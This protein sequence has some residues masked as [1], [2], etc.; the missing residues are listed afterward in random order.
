MKRVWL[1]GL[2][3][4]VLLGSAVGLEPA[5]DAQVL[6]VRGADG[7]EEYGKAFAEQVALWETAAGQAGL[8]CEVVGPEAGESCGEQVMQRL[9][10]VMKKPP[11]ALWLVLIGHGTF[12]GREAKFN[13]S[14]PDLKPEMLAEAL[15][16]FPGEVIFVH[17]GS[18]SQPFAR[19]LKGERRILVTATKSGDEVFYTRF[20]KPFAEAIGGL[21]EADL[22][23]DGQ[24]S[25]LEAFLHAGDVVASFYEEEER[26]ATEHAV[27]DDNGDGLG[28]RSEVFEGVRPKAGTPEPVDGMRARQ[29]ALMLSEAERK[30]TEAQRQRRDALEREVEALKVKR[31]EL[32]EEGYYAAL[33]KV[34]L[35]LARI[36]TGR[37]DGGR[38]GVAK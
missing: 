5:R 25:V 17:T 12:D 15:G 9:R 18:A 22:D 14:G 16:A 36:V 33:E 28:T 10:E 6:V 30:L 1:M 20:G 29:V 7:T 23:Q 19:A 27:L 13:V 4:G 24:V 34:M 38:D 8:K 37:G 3:V 31:A 32:G 21:S 26:I 35:E 11:T 2:G